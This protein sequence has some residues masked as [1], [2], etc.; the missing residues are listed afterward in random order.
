MINVKPML[1][2][3][4]MHS[5]DCA[6]QEEAVLITKFQQLLQQNFKRHYIV[7][8]LKLRCLEDYK[9]AFI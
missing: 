8:L 1:L 6:M 4:G 5:E 7:K 2:D 9:L 3:V